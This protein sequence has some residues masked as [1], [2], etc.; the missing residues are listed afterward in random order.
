MG[1]AQAR[2][3][4]VQDLG[5]VG[6]EQEFMVQVEQGDLDQ[7]EQEDLDQVEQEE[8]DKVCLEA[9][10]L[11]QEVLVLVDLEQEALVQVFIFAWR[12]TYMTES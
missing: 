4:P 6:L 1:L 2:V 8:L 10:E 5:Q 7:V 9:L 12:S 11:V 3:V